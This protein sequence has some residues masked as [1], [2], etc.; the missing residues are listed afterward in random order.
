MIRL[1][2]IENNYSIDYPQDIVRIVDVF[3][4][5]GY[6][7]S[8]GDAAKAWEQYS[9]TLCAGWIMLPEEDE[10]VFETIFYLF[11]EDGGDV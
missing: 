11:E 9:D 6:I 10:T 5:R 7:I 4:S 1:K 8:Y 2:Y 3:Y